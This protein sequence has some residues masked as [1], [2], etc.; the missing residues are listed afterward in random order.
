M[1]AHRPE[2]SRHGSLSKGEGRLK[3]VRHTFNDV[4]ELFM[5]GVSV[6][7]WLATDAA[8][9]FRGGSFVKDHPEIF[10]MLVSAGLL[11]TAGWFWA[12]LL[13]RR[14]GEER[15]WEAE[16]LAMAQTCA[17]VDGRTTRLLGRLLAAA[18]AATRQAEA[19]A[20]AQSIYDNIRVML[21]TASQIFTDR[22][23]Y[24][25]SV[26]IRLVSSD[27][28]RTLKPIR[29][30]RFGAKKRARSY[31][32]SVFENTASERVL[33]DG[34]EQFACNDLRALARQGRYVNQRP[35]WEHDYNST[36][37]VGIP[38][39]E[40]GPAEFG[41]TDPADAP[42]VGVFCIDSARGRLDVR[43]CH[44]FAHEIACRLST[45]ID[46]LVVLQHYAQRK[47]IE[48]A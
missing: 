12:Y 46:Q 45:L 3:E 35:G 19:E 48:S 43:S 47:L 18:P 9:F 36:L 11:S 7:A 1:Y 39:R 21:D 5:L 37:V 28:Q 16:F 24:Q 22:V 33:V 30:R 41:A 27:R 44:N 2:P 31:T 20:M 38:A 42:Y 15:A 14:L 8:A 40:F 17:D 23:G 6:N 13:R 26:C 29:D 10:A 4:R 25:C 32:A 34:D